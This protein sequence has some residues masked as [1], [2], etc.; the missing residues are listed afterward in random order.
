MI[1]LAHSTSQSAETP[2]NQ[3][4]MY[5][6]KNSQFL[7]GISISRRLIQL[8]GDDIFNM[9]NPFKVDRRTERVLAMGERARELEKLEKT[10]YKLIQKRASGQDYIDNLNR[11]RLNMIE[12]RAGIVTEVKNVNGIPHLAPYVAPTET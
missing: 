4:K 12:E 9:K 6:K 10:K 8:E 2:T 1:P 11:K 7:P 3:Q 5:L